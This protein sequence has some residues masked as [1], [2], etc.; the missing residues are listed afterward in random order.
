LFWKSYT[1]PNLAARGACTVAVLSRVEL[2]GDDAHL[3]APT[4]DSERDGNDHHHD[5]QPAEVVPGVHARVDLAHET[6]EQVVE[7]DREE[8]EGGDGRLHP[9]RRFRESQL[10]TDHADAEF[11]EGDDDVGGHLP[12]A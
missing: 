5:R 8:E 12:H 9:L 7:E 4:D 10:K 1:P 11:G 6:G 3:E 2:G